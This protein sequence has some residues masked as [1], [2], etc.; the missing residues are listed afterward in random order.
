VYAWVGVGLLFGVAFVLKPPL[1]GGALVC[2][3][4]L[5]RREWYR[6]GTWR[7]AAAPVLVVGIASA[8]PII[9]CAVWF[10]ARGGWEALHWTF[11]QFT[12][13][14]SQIG[15]RTT[16]SEA[17][18]QGIEEAVVR[19]SAVIAFGFI[20][21]ITLRPLHSREREA[22]WLMLGV[23][24]VNVAGIAMQH[25]F[26]Q[27]HFAGTLPVVAFVAG[28]G[29][30]KVWRRCLAGGAAGVV[31]FVTCWGLAVSMREAT[32]DLPQGFWRR[33]TIRMQYLLHSGAITTREG[34]DRELY[35][36]ADYSLDEDRQV[37]VEIARRTAADAPVY[38]W[39]FEPA[40]YWLSGR[41]PATRYIYNVAQR[42]QWERDRSR[43]ELLR[44]LQQTPPQVIVV[45]RNDTFY[46]VTGDSL[47]SAAALWQ[48]P[49]LA[50]L[51]HDQYR[52]VTSLADFD[53]YER[54]R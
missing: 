54:T 27:Y 20:A 26:F 50:R 52:F 29:V 46:M 24:A 47:D 53:L 37:A 15:W 10:A 13:G 35:S 40:I 28:I 42:A 18:Y 30:Y 49:E 38:V 11:F 12:P 31:A 14:Y 33:C 45:Q 17:Y 4:Y 8:V 32:R 34:L 23:V 1:A 51:V 43:A 5:G 6:V 9:A 44:D 39:G 2:A 48:F 7:A 21:A 19:F 3:S 22:I 41:P 25:K 36:V 16:A